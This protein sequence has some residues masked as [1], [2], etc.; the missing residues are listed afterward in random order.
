VACGEWET[1]GRSVSPWTIVREQEE[2]SCINNRCD[3]S[4]F[5]IDTRDFE[6]HNAEPKAL[7]L[8]F[9]AASNCR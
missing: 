5:L 7:Q 2:H 4:L 3:I 9:S 1:G 6:G 8:F